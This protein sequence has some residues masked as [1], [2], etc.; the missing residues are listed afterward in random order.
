V[1]EDE[2]RTGKL[3]VEF[4]VVLVILFFFLIFRLNLHDR[5]SRDSEHR[6]RRAYGGRH[7]CVDDLELGADAKPPRVA[8]EVDDPVAIVGEADEGADG[9]VGDR[10]PIVRRLGH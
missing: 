8:G 3:V 2:E 10:A 7:A 5:L 6:R 4:V 9:V 1:F